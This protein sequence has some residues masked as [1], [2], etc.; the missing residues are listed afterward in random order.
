M[1]KTGAKLQARG[2]MYKTAIQL[3]L[4]YG[5]ESWMV[6]GAMLKVLEGFHLRLARRIA[7]ITAWSTTGGEWEWPPVAESLDTS[8]I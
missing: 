2:V 3:V 7:E 6:T 4:L 8:G 5:S 1:L